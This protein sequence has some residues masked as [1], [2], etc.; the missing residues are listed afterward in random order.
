MKIQ[1]CLR[2]SAESELSCLCESMCVR[3]RETEK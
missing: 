3:E 1:I 2:V